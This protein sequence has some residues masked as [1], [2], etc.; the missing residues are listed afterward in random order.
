MFK[1]GAQC[2]S[3][4]MPMSKDPENGGL[5][6]D[7]TKSTD[8]CSFCLRNGEFCAKETLEDFRKGLDE[9]LKAKGLSWW[10]RKLTW[11][12]LPTLKRWKQ[13]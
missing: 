8:Y 11:Y 12:Q 6:A 1:L 7:G 9:M 10:I 5:N 2:Q 3:C 13:K 4:A